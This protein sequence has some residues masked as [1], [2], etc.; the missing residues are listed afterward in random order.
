MTNLK[1]FTYYQLSLD[2]E[3]YELSYQ[4]GSDK[5]KLVND[6]DHELLSLGLNEVDSLMTGLKEMIGFLTGEKKD[7]SPAEPK[8]LMPVDNPGWI[9]RDTTIERNV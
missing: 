4:H 8:P 9:H 5:V 6:S 2:G 1:T 7:F 3:S